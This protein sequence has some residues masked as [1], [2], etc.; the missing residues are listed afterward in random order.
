MLDMLILFYVYDIKCLHVFEKV[1]VD[2]K[3]EIQYMD[4][5][6]YVNDGHSGNENENP[7]VTSSMPNCYDSRR[8]KVASFG[9]ITDAPSNTFMRAPGKQFMNKIN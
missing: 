2:E 6:F 8:W 9:V 1:G 4:A 5:V 3:G 7:Y